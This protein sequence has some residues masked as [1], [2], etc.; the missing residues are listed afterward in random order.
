MIGETITYIN[1]I[2]DD[3]RLPVL[4]LRGLV[5]FPKML[6]HFD[7][8]RQKSINAINQAM[9]DG[10]LIFLTAQKDMDVDDP[11]SDD[12]YEIGVVASIKQILKMPGDGLRVLVAGVARGKTL[13]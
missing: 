9:Q 8:G 5:V 2:G 10:R 6:I 3:I 1:N 13:Q 4:A 7:V 12:L 11:T